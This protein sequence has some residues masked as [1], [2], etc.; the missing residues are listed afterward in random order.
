MFLYLIFICSELKTNARFKTNIV[1]P[2]EVRRI[3]INN[4]IN[5]CIGNNMY[6]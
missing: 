3:N 6:H 1:I 4:V 5:H 2:F